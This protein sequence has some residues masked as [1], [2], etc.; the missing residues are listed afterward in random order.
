MG[1]RRCSL[2]MLV[3][4]GAMLI[5]YSFDIMF[6]PLSYPIPFLSIFLPA[7]LLRREAEYDW[8]LTYPQVRGG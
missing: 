3:L 1:R 7:W 5:C 6:I 2:P 8:L 4:L